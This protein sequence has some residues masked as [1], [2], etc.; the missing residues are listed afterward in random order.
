M[1][2]P[3]CHYNFSFQIDNSFIQRADAETKIRDGHLDETGQDP[4]KQLSEIIP[5]ILRDNGKKRSKKVENN[6]LRLGQEIVNSAEKIQFG[7]SRTDRGLLD[8]LKLKGS[9]ETTQNNR[10]HIGKV[11]K[12]IQ[13][14]LR[15]NSDSENYNSYERKGPL[16]VEDLSTATLPN[17]VVSPTQY[18]I[19]SGSLTTSTLPQD[20]KIGS[21]STTEGDLSVNLQSRVDSELGPQDQDLSSEDSL[22]ATILPKSQTL[23]PTSTN[24]PVGE[25]STIEHLGPSSTTT[26]PTPK[27][28]WKTWNVGQFNF[29]WNNEQILPTSITESETNIGSSSRTQTHRLRHKRQIH[30]RGKHRRKSS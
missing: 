11:P 7:S 25:F 27:K 15:R 19:N 22:S 1:Q 10:L 29:F 13:E 6:S 2:T 3:E 23:N 4:N 24:R 18:T 14:N 20:H 5:V 17:R 30:P 9:Q 26:S 28:E 12:N 8:S 21:S 16:H